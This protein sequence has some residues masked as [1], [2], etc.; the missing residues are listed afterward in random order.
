MV[1]CDEVGYGVRF[2]ARI[3]GEGTITFEVLPDS[4]TLTEAGRSEPKF[5]FKRL[6]EFEA[7]ILF[8]I[9]EC[10]ASDLSDAEAPTPRLPD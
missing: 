4:L 5:V 2:T 1:E 8:A 3:S 10:W 7:W 6:K 9:C